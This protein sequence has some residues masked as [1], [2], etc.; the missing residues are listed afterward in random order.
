MPDL[1]FTIVFVSAFASL[2]VGGV[3]TVLSFVAFDRLLRQVWAESEDEWMKLGKPCGFFWVPHG[4]RVGFM[5]GFVRSGLYDKWAAVDEEPFAGCA[6]YLGKLRRYRRMS[7]W[8]LAVGA[9]LL[10][11]ALG[12]MLAQ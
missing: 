1:V 2:F 8:C 3:F 10:V 12:M 9:L 5:T 11:S 4:T 7:G 6:E